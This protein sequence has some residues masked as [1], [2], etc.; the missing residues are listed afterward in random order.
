MNKLNVL[1]LLLSMFA[2]ATITESCKKDSDTDS[3][4]DIKTNLVGTWN[5]SGDVTGMLTFN[6][7]GT[8]SETPNN[9]LI[10]D[11]PNKTWTYGSTG[12]LSLEGNDGTGGEG[13]ISAT[14][15]SNECNKVELDF[16]LFNATLTRK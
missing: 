14:V 8:F 12:F 6:S 3:C 11:F 10:G 15:E 1:I 2:V 13:T 5:V 4:S 7:D 9:L 16:F